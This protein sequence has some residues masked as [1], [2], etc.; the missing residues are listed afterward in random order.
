MKDAGSS[1][2]ERW[3]NSHLNHDTELVKREWR[4]GQK[5]RN[6]N[7]AREQK[8]ET[9]TWVTVTVT[10]RLTTTHGLG[11]MLFTWHSQLV[12]AS[13]WRELRAKHCSCSPA[14]TNES[15][16]FIIYIYDKLLRSLSEPQSTSTLSD[17]RCFA[18]MSNLCARA[19]TWWPAATFDSWANNGLWI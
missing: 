16:C 8:Q 1:K 13:L 11:H 12:Y 5:T 7:G 6:H 17:S 10:H 4:V 18:E 15:P 3:P 19:M 2:G 14:L 9:K